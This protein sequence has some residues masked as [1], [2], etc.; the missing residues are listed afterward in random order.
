MA[1]IGLVLAMVGSILYVSY[2]QWRHWRRMDKF[3]NE[4]GIDK[5]V[6]FRNQY[7]IYDN[8]L[9]YTIVKRMGIDLNERTIW[10][11]SFMFSKI[12]RNVFFWNNG[13]VSVVAQYILLNSVQSSMNNHIKSFDITS[14]STSMSASTIYLRDMNTYIDDTQDKLNQELFSGIKEISV[15]LNSTIV[16]FLDKQ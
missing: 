3:I 14:N 8:F 2:I 13:V 4:T 15:S 9:I 12:S 5:E 16:E 1:F 7:N 11:L 10:M 6:Q